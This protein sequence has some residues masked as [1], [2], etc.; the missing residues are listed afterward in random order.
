MRIRCETSAQ[1]TFDAE[2]GERIYGRD[3]EDIY[4]FKPHAGKRGA[5]SARLGHTALKHT[6]PACTVPRVAR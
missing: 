1:G 2:T 6:W 4:I 5:G 3:R